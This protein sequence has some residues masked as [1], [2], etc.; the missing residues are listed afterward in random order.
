MGLT[1]LLKNEMN[2]QINLNVSV[3][4]LNLQKVDQTVGC[5]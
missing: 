2:F 1:Q 5:S 3:K 4:S